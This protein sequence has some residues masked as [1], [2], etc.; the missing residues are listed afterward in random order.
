MIG[1]FQLK[2]LLKTAFRSILKNRMRSFLTSLGVI[3]GVAAV[4]VMVGIGTGAQKQIEDQLQSLGTDVLM[5][6]P[7][8]SRYGGVSR[9]A[10]SH[11]RFT[12]AEVEKIRAS[13]KS[14][15]TLSPVIRA[16]GQIVGGGQN[17]NTSTMGVTPAYFEVRNWGV[18]VGELFTDKDVANRRKVALLGKTVADA[19]FPSGNPVGERIRIRNVPFTVIGVLQPKGQNAAGMDQDDVVLA[20]SNTVMYRLRG[21]PD[22]DFIIASARSGE[23]VE[24][25]REE[26]RNV[27]RE[28]R[29]IRSGEDDDFTIRAQADI[30]ETATQTSRMLTLLLGAIAGISLIVGGIG[31][32]N[33]MLVS[34]T[35]RT[36]EIGIR[37]SVGARGVDVLTQFVAE[38]VVLSLFGGTIGIILS[39]VASF[40]VNRL[41][42]LPMIINP[43]TVVLVF[44]VCVV[45]GV[46]FGWY[47]A[48]KAASLNPVEALRYE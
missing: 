48:R 28:M 26:I 18:S 46:F 31:I 43:A 9:G 37:L 15:K 23:E 25:A 16:S 8:A 27:L 10:G 36:R 7:G 29:R 32:M 38:A 2:N 11:R 5:I 45:V 24:I 4:V 22:V 12:L 30:I 40:F 17:W 13:V 41:S 42:S 47:P 44:G 34:V 14:I 21:E 20:P 19:L 33:I 6:F 35:E 3:I 39:F 1:V